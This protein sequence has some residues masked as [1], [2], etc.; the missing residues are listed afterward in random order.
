MSVPQLFPGIWMGRGWPRVFRLGWGSEFGNACVYVKE[1]LSGKEVS[2][3]HTEST[4]LLT[5]KGRIHVGH[6]LIAFP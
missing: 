3:Q 4:H 5:Q 6:W 2:Q 1:V